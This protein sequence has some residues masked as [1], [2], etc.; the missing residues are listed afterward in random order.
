VN[1]K[2]LLSEETKWTT[3]AFARSK[4]GSLVG[5]CSPKAV[6]WCLAG[7]A[8]KCYG[9]EA[10]ADI[11]Q[12]IYEAAVN[13]SAG[14]RSIASWNDTHTYAEVKALVERLDI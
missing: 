8:K 2:E 5:P 13:R 1:I 14:A 9:S 10:H 12:K 6:C 11:L 3:G 4:D 7:A